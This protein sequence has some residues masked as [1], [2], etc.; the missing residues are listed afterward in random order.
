MKRFIFFVKAGIIVL[1]TIPMAIVT[2]LL[3]PFNYKG[4]IYHFMARI[5]SGLV[6][7][8][9]NV[10]VEVVG[11][12]NID[13]GKNYIYIS[14]HASAMDIPALIRGIPDQIRFLAKQELGKIP[15]WGWL[16][17]YGGYILIDRRNPKRAMRSVQMAIEKIKSGVS[18]LVFA[19]GTRSTDGKLLPFKRGGFMLAIRAKTPIVP[20]TIIGSHKIM[21]KHKLEINPGT[22]KILLDKPISVDEFDGREG[23][24]KLMELTRD[25]INR[26]LFEKQSEG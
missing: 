4:K 17:K 8:I 26:N 3:L 24:E 11:K 20:V 9:F 25:V 5:W 7:W 18:V 15:L 23:E 2:F 12:E 1:I 22:I 16:L 14:N 13:F 6:L 19:E 21:Q 10:K